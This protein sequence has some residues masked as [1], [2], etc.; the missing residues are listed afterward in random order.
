MYLFCTILIEVKNKI[1]SFDTV[2]YEYVIWRL[3][4][5]IR[6]CSLRRKIHCMMNVKYICL[7]ESFDFL[8]FKQH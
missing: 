7:P 2:F 8:F 6:S 4:H 3:C 5:F 1:A